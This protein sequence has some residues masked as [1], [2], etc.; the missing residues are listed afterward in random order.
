MPTMDSPGNVVYRVGDV[1]VDTSRGCIRL[2]QQEHHLRQQAFQVLVYLLE[3]HERLVTKEELMDRVWKDTAVTDDVLVQCVMDIRKAIGDDSRNPRFVRT[4]PKVGYRFIG[5]VELQP[6][7][8]VVTA[9]TEE[10][11]S[12]EVEIE[13]EIPDGD[14][15]R[16]VSEALPALPP[17]A[18]TR[19]RWMLA[20]ALGFCLIVAAALP[21]G[22]RQ[23]I[24]RSSKP[25]PE[26]T[27]PHLA[28]KKPLVVMRFENQSGSADLDWLRD[29][30][31]DMLITN[32]SR[33]PKL[34]V[35]SRQQLHLL[36]TRTGHAESNPIQ[37]EEALEMA[38]RSKAEAVVLGS[39]ARIGEK[40]R[41][42]VQ[43]HDAGTGQ[44]IQSESFAVDRP[45]Q[46]LTQIDL[47]SMKLATRVGGAAAGTERKAA[48]ADVM[49]NNLEAYRYYSLALERAQAKHSKEAIS[50][51][52]KA[53]A[54]DPQFAM[55]YARI[56]Y[57]YAV[58][59]GGFTEK[60]KP[61]LERAFQ[62]SD[63]LTEKDRLNIAA[64]YSIANQDFS[65]ALRSFREIIAR[66]PMESEAYWRLGN[67]L[68]GEEQYEE[69]IRVLQQGLAVDPEA[70][71]I[72]N[73]LGGV[74][75]TLGR[76]DQAIAACSRYV[77]LAPQES[78]AH[79][80][81]GLAYQWAG[82]C[83]EAI[84]EYKRALALQ[85]DF[86]IARVHLGNVYF[87][88]GQYQDAIR[89]FKE[90]I[91]VAPSTQ[92]R[93]R[94][95]SEVAWVYSR[96]RKWDQAQEA[97]KGLTQMNYWGAH[98]AMLL[99]L[100]RG[101]VTA[102]QKFKARIS[103]ELSFPDR[104]IRLSARYQKFLDGYFNL[105]TGHPTEAIA[106]FKEVLQHRPLIWD[107]DAY[108]DCLANAYLKLGQTDDAI[109]EYERILR[110]NP[111]YPLAHFHLAQAYQHKGQTDRARSEYRQ[112]LQVWKNADPD[113]PIL[114]EAKAAYAKLE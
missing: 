19:R 96:Q 52:E 70:S 63:R 103:E 92:E 21:I 66:Y 38:R 102:A 106:L 80:S 109:A 81:L 58:G 5:S 74:Y 10:A 29:G 16:A 47:L 76:H 107:I 73:S 93:D 15:P 4:I 82:R 97:V 3:R 112:F 60:G 37:L 39:F 101:D 90:Y 83:D 75:S 61:Y 94:G 9:E 68:V 78:N 42:S 98:V 22:L 99:A 18:A 25:I 72:Y 71:D 91:H 87:Q 35:L 12:V 51:L 56:G 49:T 54:L 43:L 24:Y 77:A 88:L 114:K 62:L 55:A 104:G 69:A 26:A 44:L 17:A 32:L 2:G 46:I 28:G 11:T 36:L 111:N 45:E 41:V 110:L 84:E 65:G 67:L 31:C 59:W 64:W 20:L 113:I 30:L 100:E 95:I 86:E 1:E 14:F 85:P 48:L 50:L 108:E 33:S 13:E 27:L 23:R 89:E 40:T 6:A 53:I 8:G 7:G 57:A 105:Q 34:T 79:D